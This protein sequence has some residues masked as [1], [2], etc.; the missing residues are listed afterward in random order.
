M[1]GEPNRNG[2]KPPWHFRRRIIVSTLVFCA[3]ST[4]YAMKQG[5]EMVDAVIGSMAALAGTV[6]AAAIGGAVWD[7]KR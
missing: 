7:D 3:V 6:I 5:P 2:D 1:S 4:A